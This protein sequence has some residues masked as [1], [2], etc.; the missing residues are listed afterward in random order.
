MGKW[1]ELRDAFVR[2][3]RSGEECE[4]FF[5][6]RFLMRTIKW[7]GT[8]VSYIPITGSSSSSTSS[9]SCY[10]NFKATQTSEDETFSVQ[11]RQH[12]E[13]GTSVVNDGHSA[14]DA[15]GSV[16][17]DDSNVPDDDGHVSDNGGSVS[18]DDSS[19]SAVAGYWSVTDGMV[20]ERFKQSRRNDDRSGSVGKDGRGHT[21]GPS[22]PLPKVQNEDDKFLAFV[23]SSM[24]NFT[25]IER[26]EFRVSVLR[27]LQ[28]FNFSRVMEL[29][30]CLRQYQFTCPPC[31][32]PICRSPPLIT[33]CRC[34]VCVPSS[35]RPPT[36]SREAP[37]SGSPMSRSPMMGLSAITRNNNQYRN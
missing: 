30:R 4:F 20:A 32:D 5:R 18:D 21:D 17:N 36:Q 16:P 14:P 12:I 1:H 19:V 9:E 28:G 23:A 31:S 3:L 34:N 35:P 25:E 2:S 11:Q 10:Q 26:V 29:D 37:P 7:H 15:G 33:A 8:D 13:C 22:T 24:R 6:L 27:L